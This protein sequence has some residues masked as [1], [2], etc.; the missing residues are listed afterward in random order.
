LKII[1][2]VGMPGSGKSVASE[3]ARNMGL[4]VIVMGDVI[5]QEANR[6]GLAFTDENLGNVGNML[7]AKEGPVAVSRRTLE[8][9]KRSNKDLTV[10]DGIRSKAEV[11]F[12]K[13]NSERF[14]LIEICASSESRQRR[15]ECRGRSDDACTC[16]KSRISL[17]NNRLGDLKSGTDTQQMSTKI[18]EKRE[19]R[20]LGWGMFEAIKEADLRIKNDCDLASF[21]ANVEATIKEIM[22]S[23]EN[24]QI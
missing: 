9:A 8:W 2:F 17:D 21:K 4:E 20:E 12:F 14:W 13:S 5:R 19:N 16:V 15:I 22:N 1:G 3:V 6:L 23:L 18:L 10:V 24:G 7:R 11:E